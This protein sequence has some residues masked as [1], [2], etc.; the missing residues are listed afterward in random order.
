MAK[1]IIFTKDDGANKKGDEKSFHNPLADE[2]VEQG[3]A[4]YKNKAD[5]PKKVDVL[6]VKNTEIDKKIYRS[7]KEANILESIA[8]DKQTNGY[9]K[10]KKGK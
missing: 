8:L 5:A 6:F 10:I 9:L 2:K 4:K 3:I 7:G 1:T